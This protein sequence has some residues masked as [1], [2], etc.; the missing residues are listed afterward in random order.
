MNARNIRHTF[1][2]DLE[3]NIY[4]NPYYFDKEKVYLRAQIGRINHSTQLTAKTLYKLDPENP[5][6]IVE[7][8][9]EGDDAPIPKPTNKQMKGLDMWVHHPVTLLRQGRLVHKVPAPKDEED[10][11]ELAK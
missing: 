10:P 4:T 2:G 9:A 8:V 7:N 5:R 3:S 6:E 11:E 1:T